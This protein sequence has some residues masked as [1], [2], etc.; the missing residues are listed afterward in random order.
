MKTNGDWQEKNKRK[1][2]EQESKSWRMFFHFDFG[3]FYL[4]NR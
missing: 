1:Q 3:A 2:N 4:C